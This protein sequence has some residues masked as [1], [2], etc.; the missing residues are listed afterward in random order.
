[1]IKNIL[2]DIGGVLVRHDPMDILSGMDISEERKEHLFDLL[3]TDRFFNDVDLGI[4]SGMLAALPSFKERHP[5]AAG[6]L[7]AFFDAGFMKSYTPLQ[8]GQELLRHFHEKG[9]HIYLLSNFSKDGIEILKEKFDFFQY[10]DGELISYRVKL[11]KPDLRI[12]RLLL[13]K[14]DLMAEECLF[15][16]DREDNVM[17]A[18][19]AGLQAVIFDEKTIDSKLKTILD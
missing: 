12:Y 6:D 1:M 9:Y 14:F 19:N 16:D 3:R 8:K 10:V 7:Q 4:Y 17:A 15:L 18:R 11:V 2:F 5:E 13:E